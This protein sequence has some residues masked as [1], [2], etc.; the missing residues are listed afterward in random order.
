MPVFACEKGRQSFDGIH[1][2]LV[3]LVS[4]V[5]SQAVC[6]AYFKYFKII[7]QCFVIESKGCSCVDS[8]CAAYE[9]LPLVFRIEVDERLPGEKPFLHSECPVH[10]CLFGRGE[11][12]F[13]FSGRKFA[14]EYHEHCSHSDTVVGSES[15]LPGYHPT[16]LD[17]II[18]GVGQEVVGGSGGFLA[19]HVL[20]SLK[21]QCADIFLTRSGFLD[22]ADISDTVGP[23]FEPSGM[24]EADEV[25]PH[26]FLI[27]RFTGDSGYLLEVFKD[28]V[29]IFH[30]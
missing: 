28:S 29:G 18:N 21:D 24:R 20:V 22:Y 19:D 11:D 17:N 6:Y 15:G 10:S 7:I 4:A 26:P 27:P 1:P 30:K 25:F 23:A 13:D 12:T 3:D 5:P 2:A 16:V 14:P 9:E 8:S